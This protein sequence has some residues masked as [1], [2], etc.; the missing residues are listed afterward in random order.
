MT[1]EKK[2]WLCEQYAQKEWTLS[3]N[4]AQEAV[5]A[6]R[7]GKGYAVVAEETRRLADNLFDYVAKAR[8]DGNDSD[9]KGIT[10]FALATGFLSVNAA[11]EA[12][13]VEDSERGI[14]NM[15]IFVEDLRNISLGLRELTGAKAPSSAAM[16]DVTSA[17][18]ISPYVMPEIASPITSSRKADWFFRF[19]AGGIAL[20]EN[21]ANLVEIC[22]ARK[23]DVGGDTFSPRGLPQS[24]VPLINLSKRFGLQSGNANA[25]WQPVMIVCPDGQRF[26]KR[27]GFYAVLIDDLDINAIFRSRIGYNAQPPEEHKLRNHTR[28]CWDVVGGEQIV[29]LDWHSLIDR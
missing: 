12:L 14:E 11:I 2:I 1:R 13:G 28:E 19:S 27:D 18:Y 25:D 26:G 3:S 8:F 21:T 29:F 15:L 23:A 5:S 17:A 20:A 7:L 4:I 10:D 6:G 22:N 9:F 16:P 24:R